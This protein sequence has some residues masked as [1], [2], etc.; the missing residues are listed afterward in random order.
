MIRTSTCSA[1]CRYCNQPS[2]L[3][4][5][6]GPLH[7]CCKIA[8]ENTRNPSGRC[9]GCG[10]SLAFWKRE[11]QKRNI[12]LGQSKRTKKSKGICRFCDNKLAPG[13]VM[14]DGQFHPHAEGDCLT[15][16]ERAHVAFTQR[17]L[18]DLPAALAEAARTMKTC[19]YCRCRYGE[20]A[21]RSSGDTKHCG[22]PDCQVAAGE[23]HRVPL[24]SWSAN[25]D[26][27][28]P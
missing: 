25:L 24:G 18:A 21:K 2:Y 11:E 5:G 14:P 26:L 16:S 4:D 6:D 13:D 15:G 17:L 9:P 23:I 27:P 28:E 1:P 22:R 20:N 8:A 3:L 10:S 12:K 7:P 19:P